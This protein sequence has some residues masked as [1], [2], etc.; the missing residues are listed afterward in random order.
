VSVQTATTGTTEQVTP[1]PASVRVL[2]WLLA[3]TAVAT[4]A[5][6]W[7]NWWYAPEGG[8]SLAVRTGWALLRSL[9]FLILIWHVRRGRA[10]AP[11]F[12]LILAVTTIFSVAR[13]VVPKQGMPALPGV[14]GFTFVTLLCLVVVTLLYRL[15]A[16]QEH[17]SRHPTRP[18]LTREGLVW[19]PV[20]PRQPA[21]PGW[22]LTARVA[23]FTYSPLMLVACVI[24][25]GAVFDGELA[26]VPVL[27]VWFVAGFVTSYAVLFTT[28]FL[29]RGRPWARVL[30]VLLTL[31]VLAL[32]LPLCW[33]LLGTDGLI[34][35]GGPLAVAAAL[36]LYGL[37]RAGRL[38]P[39]TPV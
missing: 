2:S 17:L 23:A 22:L 34:R 13:L 28:F 38:R 9:G 3:V 35:D 26:A 20:P 37:W 11:P 29:M 6:E 14:L 19:R 25:L 39:A 4:A 30:L 8:Y 36:T 32:D 18:V 33:V 12:G 1:T 16:L 15:Q 21:V 27:V 31:A 10:G 24:A 7:L 5:V